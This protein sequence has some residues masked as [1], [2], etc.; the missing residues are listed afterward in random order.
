[1]I[2]PRLFSSI[3]LGPAGRQAF[4]HEFRLLAFASLIML[5]AD[6]AALIHKLSFRGGFV[7]ALL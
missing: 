6:L 3:I 5:A 1:M 7:Q 4:Y 2:S